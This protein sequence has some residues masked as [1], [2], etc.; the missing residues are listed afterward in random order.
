MNK[1][2]GPSCARWATGPLAVSYGAGPAVSN[3][4]DAIGLRIKRCDSHRSGTARASGHYRRRFTPD[5]ET[6]ISFASVAHCGEVPGIAPATPRPTAGNPRSRL[7]S[8]PDVEPA[9]D[10][11]GDDSSPVS[12][13]IFSNF[14]SSAASCWRARNRGR[15]GT[16]RS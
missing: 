14:R 1:A 2:R 11:V 4:D 9:V 15:D 16:R 12:R 6:R 8:P 5:R 10:L 13:R 7:S 3:L